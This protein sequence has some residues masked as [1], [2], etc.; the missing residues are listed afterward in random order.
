M[1][2]TAVAV[3]YYSEAVE[4][5]QSPVA[6]ANTAIELCGGFGNVGAAKAADALPGKAAAGVVRF[7]GH[8]GLEF[9][10]GDDLINV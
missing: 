4:V 3:S 1:A 6:E 5:G 9:K 10:G 2:L 8:P 7:E